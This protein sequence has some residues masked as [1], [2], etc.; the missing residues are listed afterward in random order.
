MFAE[1]DYRA[2][3]SIELCA[4]EVALLFIVGGCQMRHQT[5]DAN[6]FETPQSVAELRDIFR[7]HSQATHASV[8]LDVNI[9]SCLR[10]CCGSIQRFN[11]IY[12]VHDGRAIVLNGK[13]LLAS[14]TS[15]Q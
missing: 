2:I 1:C 11:R 10:V 6:I 3:E 13:T 12:S 5:V 9:N 8:D 14:P 7:A 15:G 4:S